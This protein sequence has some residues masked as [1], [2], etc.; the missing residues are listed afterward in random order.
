MLKI[1]KSTIGQNIHVNSFGKV[2][3]SFCQFVVDFVSMALVFDVWS[4]HLSQ[5]VPAPYVSG[6]LAAVYEHMHNNREIIVHYLQSNQ[7]SYAGKIVLLEFWPSCILTNSYTYHFAELNCHHFTF[8]A[9]N[10]V[11]DQGPDW[12]RPKLKQ[13]YS[14]LVMYRIQFA[15]GV[16]SS[17]DNYNSNQVGSFFICVPILSFLLSSIGTFVG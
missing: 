17:F 16:I 8:P 6:V 15:G 11:F 1:K 14:T 9:G 3:K 10:S 2:N 7:V 5:F 13:L 12:D 4:S